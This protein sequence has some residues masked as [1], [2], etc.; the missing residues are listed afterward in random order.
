MITLSI[1]FIYCCLKV[2]SN[3]TKLEEEFN[4]KGKKEFIQNKKNL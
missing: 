3:C 4:N 1:L 2:S